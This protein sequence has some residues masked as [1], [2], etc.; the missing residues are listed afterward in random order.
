M[1]H[2]SDDLTTG[3]TNSGSASMSISWAA[4]LGGLHDGP[5]VFEECTGSCSVMA[6]GWSAPESVPN[7][8][9]SVTRTCPAGRGHLH[10][11]R[12]CHEHR[13]G[14]E[15]VDHVALRPGRAGAV[16]RGHRAG[17]RHRDGDVHGST[18]TGPASASC[19]LRVRGVQ[20]RLRHRHQLVGRRPRPSR[21]R[22]RR[23]R[24]PPMSPARPRPRRARSAFAV[25]ERRRATQHVERRVDRD[26]RLTLPQARRGGGLRL[27]VIRRRG[28]PRTSA[29]CEPSRPS[30]RPR[31]SRADGRSGSRA[32]RRRSGRPRCRPARRGELLA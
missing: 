1:T 21:T 8:T 15:R 6:A 28:A 4:P 27:A 14:V 17:E 13:G 10:V 18:G 24:P 25:R 26:R 16:D 3:N 29:A 19:A 11:P 31:R 23:A 12:A 9:L 30:P 7:A 20:P 5:Y 2:A 32:W 22:L